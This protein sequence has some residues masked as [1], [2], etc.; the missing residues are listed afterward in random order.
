MLTDYE[1]KV[2]TPKTKES[3]ICPSCGHKEWRKVVK[4]SRKRLVCK[5]C[6]HVKED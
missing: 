5:V 2:M 3:N 4:R 6:G 1:N